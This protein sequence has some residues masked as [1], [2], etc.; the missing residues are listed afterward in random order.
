[1]NPYLP[2]P[3]ETLKLTENRLQPH[4]AAAGD[5][6]S[7]RSI[8]CR[9]RGRCTRLLTAAG[10]P[11]LLQEGLPIRCLPVPSAHLATSVAGCQAFHSHDH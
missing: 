1:M 2:Q 11:E 7:S 9:A 5:S 6:M 8:V 10:P 3:T 4:R